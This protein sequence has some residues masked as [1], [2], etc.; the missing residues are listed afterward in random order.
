ML[1]M[2]KNDGGIVK[3]NLQFEERERSYCNLLKQTKLFAIANTHNIHT[4]SYVDGRSAY[5]N[6]EAMTQT[7]V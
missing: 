6:K 3:K 5:R 1:D 2:R 7:I 4:H